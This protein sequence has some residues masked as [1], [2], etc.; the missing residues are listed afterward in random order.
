VAILEANS[1]GVPAVATRV[2]GVPDVLLHGETGFVAPPDDADALTQFVALLARDETKRRA[3][4]AAARQ[5]VEQNFSHHV[6]VAR[7][8]QLFRSLH[9]KSKGDMV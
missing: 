5:W 7:Y 9:G 2:G 3:M 6:M 1:C 4:G 8:A